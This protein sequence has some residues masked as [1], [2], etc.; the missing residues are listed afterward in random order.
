MFIDNYY[1]IYSHT[2]MSRYVWQ[3]SSLVLWFAIR[4]TT[5][6]LEFLVGETVELYDELTVSG[7]DLSAGVDNLDDVQLL[8]QAHLCTDLST[9][10]LNVLHLAVETDTEFY[11]LFFFIF[12]FT[13]CLNI[14]AY[15]ED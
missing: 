2:G 13:F 4:T 10:V 8:P 6:L 14:P 9:Q 7:R 12:F 15:T 11:V 5:H 3:K 1:F